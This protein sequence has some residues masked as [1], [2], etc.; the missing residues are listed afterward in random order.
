[1]LIDKFFFSLFLINSFDFL[2]N[3]DWN[4]FNLIKFFAFKK[5]KIKL[6]IHN[7]ALNKF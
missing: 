1:M 4:Y 5:I 3:N 7:I 2:T 6:I